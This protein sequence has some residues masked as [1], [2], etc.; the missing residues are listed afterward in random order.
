[1]KKPVI[2]LDIDRS[3]V[4][5]D[6]DSGSRKPRVGA[7]SEGAK[8]QN[9]YKEV[10]RGGAPLENLFPFHLLLKGKGIQGIGL[11]IND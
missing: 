7:P 6:T 1:M 4:F 9:S 3:P 8:P 11:P 2:L 5:T 10:K